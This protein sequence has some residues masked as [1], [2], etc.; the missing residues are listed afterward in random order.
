MKKPHS[1]I[2]WI[3]AENDEVWQ[4][5][6]AQTHREG[7][8]ATDVAI[9][10]VPRK[11]VVL[12]TLLAT[13]LLL[14]V[15]GLL[16]SRSTPTKGA[17]HKLSLNAEQEEQTLTQTLESLDN[18]MHVNKIQRLG[19]RVMAEVT[20]EYEE[21]QVRAYRETRFYEKSA[22]GWQRIP[23][24]PTLLGPQNTLKSANFTILYH[25]VD[26][27]AAFEAAPKLEQLYATLR[28][29]FG[30]PAVVST[31][32]YTV[33]VD[34]NALD[35]EHFS[36]S[37]HK[38]T[39]SSPFLLSLPVEI[40]PATAV[41]EEAILPLAYLLIHEAFYQHDA[42][43]QF[44]F[45]R[46][47]PMENGL[48]LWE[49]WQEE[50][51]LASS[52]NIITWLYRMTEN[53]NS[54]HSLPAGYIQLCHIH[55][56]GQLT[57]SDLMIPHFCSGQD[58]ERVPTH[59]DLALASTWPQRNDYG[60]R[61]HVSPNPYSA[62]IT[63]ETIIEYIVAIYGRDKLPQFFN[64]LGEYTTPDTLIPALFGV[65]RAHFEAGWQAY[66]AQHF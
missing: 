31:V 27:D 58:A 33:E 2:D 51:L 38:L 62:P 17:I 19:D 43:W 45:G 29:D 44:N 53:P 64:A 3:V 14:L 55:G 41:E 60:S 5:T 54:R 34:G 18:A 50:G 46:W 59:D 39:I 35:V 8:R 32:V 15:G 20:A 42:R 11:E 24:D 25:V 65:S 12:T 21:D 36:Y 48:A 61:A 26:A 13:L 40:T 37:Q 57:S 63:L 9:N 56:I 6:Q 7:N 4:A 10:T 22:S 47:Y 52:H 49:L 66:L 30:L 16:W 1:N 23:P 28:Y